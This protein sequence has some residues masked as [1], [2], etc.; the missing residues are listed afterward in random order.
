M[1]TVV[2]NFDDENIRT[3]KPPNTPNLYC[4]EDY[5]AFVEEKLDVIANLV[6]EKA[7]RIGEVVWLIN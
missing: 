6:I 1:K 2:I 4:V 3:I 5:E 7:Q